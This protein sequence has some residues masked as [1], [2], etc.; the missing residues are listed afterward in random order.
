MLFHFYGLKSRY[1]FAKV[2]KTLC[3]F[4]IHLK[5][6]FYVFEFCFFLRNPGKAIQIFLSCYSDILALL[7]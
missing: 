3:L 6:S 7:W 4:F 5:I 1:Y 2:F